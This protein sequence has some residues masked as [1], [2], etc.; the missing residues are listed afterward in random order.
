MKH[1]KTMAL[2][3]SFVSFRGLSQEVPQNSPALDS[4]S[5]AVIDANDGLRRLLFSSP[6]E[7]VGAHQL[8][9]G[10]GYSEWVSAQEFRAEIASGSESQ[11][12]YL[13]LM[14]ESFNEFSDI[15]FFP[16]E[17]LLKRLLTW[18]EANKYVNRESPIQEI[19]AQNEA[20]DTTLG[21]FS[22][23][24][25]VT[26][27]DLETWSQRGNLRLSPSQQL[28]SKR[29]AQEALT[30]YHR[31]YQRIL[32]SREEMRR[33]R[34]EIS[35]ETIRKKSLALIAHARVLNLQAHL[36]QAALSTVAD[37]V[38]QVEIEL[39]DQHRVRL[40]ELASATWTLSPTAVYYP[41][42][43][44]EGLKSIPLIGNRSRS[45]DVRL[46]RQHYTTFTVSPR[47]RMNHYSFDLSPSQ[48]GSMS[49]SMIYEVFDLLRPHEA[50]G[51]QAE[52]LV[53]ERFVIES[54]AREYQLSALYEW[55]R[56]TRFSSNEELISSL[57]KRMQRQKEPEASSNL[58][59]LTSQL[60]VSRW[61]DKTN[62]LAHLWWSGVVVNPDYWQMR[63]QEAQ[64]LSRSQLSWFASGRAWQES[65]GVQADKNDK[66]TEKEL[67]RREAH[68]EKTAEGRSAEIRSRDRKWG[69]AAVAAFV[70][71]YFGSS[72]VQEPSLPR[73]DN[74]LKSSLSAPDWL[75]DLLDWLN[76]LGIQGAGERLG[77]NSVY[78][79][80]QDF[81]AG[82]Y[83]LNEGDADDEPIKDIRFEVG[84]ALMP[85]SVAYFDLLDRTNSSESVWPN[86]F[87]YREIQ[88]SPS[89]SPAPDKVF[90]ESQ[91][92]MR[93]FNFEIEKYSRAYQKVYPLPSLQG[94][95]IAEI[96]VTYSQN[97][98]WNRVQGVSLAE[99]LT[100]IESRSN[101][102][103][104]LVWSYDELGVDPT[105]VSLQILF[106]K[107]PLREGTYNLQQFFDQPMNPS[108]VA[109]VIEDKLSELSDNRAVEGI[110]E[111]VAD[112]GKLTFD[113]LARTTAFNS[114]YTFDRGPRLKVFDWD[115][116]LSDFKAF[117]RD[118]TFWWQCTGSN[119]FNI[120]F[121]NDYFAIA[122]GS[123]TPLY[124]R[125]DGSFADIS[126][127]AR[128]IIGYGLELD[129][130]TG[131]YHRSPIGHVRSEITA[132]DRYEE[133]FGSHIVDAT[134][135]APVKLPF[136]VPTPPHSQ[137]W[138]R[139]E[140]ARLQ[141]IDDSESSSDNNKSDSSTGVNNDFDSNSSDREEALP[142][143]VSS[144]VYQL[145]ELRKNYLDFFEAEAARNSL[146][147]RL[148][149]QRGQGNARQPVPGLE[150]LKLIRHLLDSLNRHSTIDFERLVD[151]LILVM[152]DLPITTEVLRGQHQSNS[153]D[154][155][156]TA[157]E[158]YVVYLQKMGLQL[159]P[160]ILNNTL[161]K[162][163]EW[164]SYLAD[165]NFQALLRGFEEAVSSANW[166]EI[167]HH[168]NAQ[169]RSGLNRA[170]CL[171]YVQPEGAR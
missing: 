44:L 167:R 99:E 65:P 123:Y 159:Q 96:S 156:L 141:A 46:A 45:R 63:D 11:S 162:E 68:R 88:N 43:E 104:G 16:E 152:N 116:K 134:P 41:V 164:Q 14:N 27:R 137:P 58:K 56:T 47:D 100:L 20:L 168:V 165:Q 135:S 128:P 121:L 39:E 132:Y 163:Q 15:G 59:S 73:L 130:G 102:L 106:E 4:P 126:A 101:H 136:E 49:A 148:I 131:V 111:R 48:R 113:G 109:L 35:V 74:P 133:T 29:R 112:G 124:S 28:E 42:L 82:N 149:A 76:F 80:D 95:R 25:T 103:T 71:L 140:R 122:R 70:A 18:L 55:L 3:L 142:D 150:G 89:L 61:R 8:F 30:F 169:A 1:L 5:L 93:T 170:G 92:M 127:R 32:L 62:Q 38:N 53:R 60:R 145:N 33:E 67:L 12:A 84:A 105:N 81:E 153:I 139:P 77:H 66:M 83:G 154:D 9:F 85:F 108:V 157:F 115:T 161:P 17:A 34:P 158:S 13:E 54:M 146:V 107:A 69:S 147:G 21:R 144:F 51:Q 151:E 37:R 98:I 125:P 117:E 90:V 40:N 166:E 31:L 97:G 52:T 110:T 6:P 72:W 160:L 91:M 120:L 118:D 22:Y 10:Q 87:K 171:K 114:N 138:I 86:E 7:F 78:D 2:V 143:S 75:R 36:R 19:S 119:G 57:A 94:Y 23:S 64:K 79:P 26:L 155:L 24:S 50:R 129:E